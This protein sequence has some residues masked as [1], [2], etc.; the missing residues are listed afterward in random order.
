METW[1][2]TDEEDSVDLC[3]IVSLNEGGCWIRVHMVHG[4]EASYSAEVYC[5]ENSNRSGKV[6]MSK[7]HTTLSSDN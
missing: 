7:E 5:W 4:T 6:T 2:R 3:R 1:T